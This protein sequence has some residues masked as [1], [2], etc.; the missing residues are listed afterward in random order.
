MSQFI[1][2]A[3]CQVGPVLRK[4]QSVEKLS[5]GGIITHNTDSMGTF[6]G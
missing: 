5:G 4:R 3:E 6:L 1:I 2:L